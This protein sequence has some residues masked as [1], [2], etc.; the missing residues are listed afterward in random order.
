MRRLSIHDDRGQSRRV[1]SMN[2]GKN[3]P[4]FP[5]SEAAIGIRNMEIT[6]VKRL[7]NCAIANAAFLAVSLMAAVATAG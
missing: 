1:L 4:F 2:L 3:V 7:L 5:R 6:I